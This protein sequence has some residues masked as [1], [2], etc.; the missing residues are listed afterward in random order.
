MF[1]TTQG[2]QH[3]PVSSV[4]TS[5]PVYT[6]RGRKPAIHTYTYMGDPLLHI[7]PYTGDTPPNTDTAYTHT[8]FF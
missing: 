4:V 3:V 2:S 5:F 7:H 6:R 1:Y 8:V